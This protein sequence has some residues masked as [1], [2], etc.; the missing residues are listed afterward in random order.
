MKTQK[1]NLGIAFFF[2][3]V[4]I[5]IGCE[6]DDDSE[7]TI[8]SEY[9]FLG[10]GYDVFDN[11]ADASKVKGQILDC[12][13]LFENS[14]IEKR[15]IEK[16]TFDVIQGTTAEEYLKTFSNKTKLEGSYK[17]FSGSLEVNYSNELY[18]NSSNSFA[19]VQSVINKYE[20]LV[21]PEYESDDLKSYLTEK[22]E[23]DINDQSLSYATI[24]NRYGTHCMRKVVVGGRL[25][26]NVAAN[27][28]YISSSSSIE[29]HA[30][31]A[32]KNAFASAEINNTTVST[33]DQ[34]NFESHMEKKLVVYGGASEYGQNIINDNDYKSWIASI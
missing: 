2:L 20:Y 3:L 22:F 4:I 28:T 32:Y 33:E 1:L 10:N 15:V 23:N 14:I 21:K 29:V 13:K 16:G 27:D 12:Q 9:D 25:D 17:Y 5:G 19:T 30:R 34:S 24:F 18:T 26:F 8:S 6:K 7:T 11:Y 31:A